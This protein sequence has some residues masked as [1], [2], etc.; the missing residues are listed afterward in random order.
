MILGSFCV[1]VSK[2]QVRCCVMTRINVIDPTVLTDQ[3]A[4]AEYRELPM[5][6]GSLRR[7]LLSRR[8]LPPIP[9]AYTL[10]AGHVTFFYNKGKFLEDRYRALV[11]ELTSRGYTLDPD[12]AADFTMFTDNGLYGDW[13]PDRHALSINAERITER[14]N[15]K[16]HWYRYNGVTLNTLDPRL[17]AALIHPEVLWER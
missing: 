8:G 9:K 17:Q 2:T 3:H 6:M 15:Q 16:P 5:V 14:I 13:L 1:L 12:R 4:M 11:N 7:S 10:N